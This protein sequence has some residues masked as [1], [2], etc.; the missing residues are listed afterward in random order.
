MTTSTMI[1]WSQIRTVLLDMDGTLLDLHFDNHFWLVHLPQ[2]YAQIHDLTE[3]DARRYLLQ[4]IDAEKGSLNWYCLDYWSGRLDL[5]IRQ[6]K[7]EIRDRIAF[8]PHV[9]EFLRQLRGQGL[10][11][12]IVTNAHQGSL[13]LK[14]E[15]VGLGP[16]VDAIH[17]THSFGKP[18]EDPSFWADLGAV[19]PFQLNQTL[20]IDD[21][22]PVLKSARRFGFEHLLAILA[23]DS[24]QAPHTA[25]DFMAVHHFDE[26]WPAGN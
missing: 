24:R 9:P 21:S 19:E 17:S 20:L 23:P 15:T 1:D 16:L 10:R 4:M 12:V 26:I 25:P 22:I 6:L 11:T 7:E 13:S 3:D 5:D 8:R 2:R 14:L 18:K